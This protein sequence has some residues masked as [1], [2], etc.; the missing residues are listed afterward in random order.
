MQKENKQWDFAS[1]IMFENC[2]NITFK[3]IKKVAIAARYL[4]QRFCGP[5]LYPPR[6]AIVDWDVH[7]GNG[8]QLCFESD[9]SCL[10]L[11]LHRH[12]NGNFFPG[13]FL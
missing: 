6:I 3:I 9:S 2:F 13:I 8:T 4:Q 7:H 1:L 5:S 10:Y 12:D 11:S